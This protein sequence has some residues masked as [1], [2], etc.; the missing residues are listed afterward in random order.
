MIKKACLFVAL[1]SFIGVSFAAK[2]ISGEYY[3]HG[4][5]LNYHGEMS[6]QYVAHKNYLDANGFFS[7]N[8]FSIYSRYHSKP[9]KNLSFA[10]TNCSRKF[11][12]F[13]SCNCTV[14]GVPA[15]INFFLNGNHIAA[16]AVT[17]AANHRFSQDLDF[18]T[19]S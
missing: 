3:F 17:F 9:M 7:E 15:R 8:M 19:R 2:V 12:Q 14:G 4:K 18:I 1:F 10:I 13:C 11:P 16:F 6:L 5:D